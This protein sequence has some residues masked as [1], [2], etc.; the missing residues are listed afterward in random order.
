M[1]SDDKGLRAFHTRNS[2]DEQACDELLL[3]FHFESANIHVKGF[4]RLR[5]TVAALDKQYQ[6]GGNVLFYFV[7]APRLFGSIC[8]NLHKACFP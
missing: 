5:E 7:M 6:T 1:G 8:E 4:A 2:F 3:R